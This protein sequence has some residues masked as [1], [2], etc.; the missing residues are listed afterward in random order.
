MRLAARARSFNLTVTN[1]P[2][3]QIPLYMI[4]SRML[5]AYPLGPLFLDQALNIALLSYDGRL[6]WG[7]NGDWDVLPD[8]RD[9]V[10]AI[11]ASFDELLR[12][13]ETAHSRT[14]TGN[15]QPRAKDPSGKH[16]R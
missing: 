12:V 11:R 10:T 13:T 3:P 16:K 15:R 9:L 2:G 8:L 14:R 5:A 7:F 4:G 6:H 1:V